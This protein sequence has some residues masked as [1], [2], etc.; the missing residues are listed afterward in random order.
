MNRKLHNHML[1]RLMAAFLAAA[2]L[3]LTVPGFGTRAEAAQKGIVD[4]QYRVATFFENGR[5]TDTDRR[6]AR[7][8]YIK[9]AMGGNPKAQLYLGE[10]YEDGFLEENIKPNIDAAFSWYIRAAIAGEQA[11]SEKA[12]YILS[13]GYNVH[14]DIGEA[15]D[16]LRRSAANGNQG[17]IEELERLKKVN[18]IDEKSDIQTTDGSHSAMADLDELIGMETIKKD[19]RELINLVKMQKLR[20][21]KGM[22]SL[23]VSLHMVFTGNPGTGKTTVARIMA[24]IYREIGVLSKGQLVEV[25]RAGLVAGYVG[26][27]AIKTQEKI[28]EANGGI[29][30]IDEAYTLAKKGNDY[31]QEAIDTLI[32]LMEKRRDNFIV[33][34]A[35]YPDLMK[36]FI[37]S[38]PG[39]KSRF[40]K[41]IHFPDYSSE[42][43]VQIFMSLCDKYEYRLTDEAAKVIREKIENHVK[44][45]NE[46]FSNGRDIRNM[47]ETIISNQASRVMTD[48]N[49][50]DEELM[51]INETDIG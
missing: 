24:D 3:L 50:S 1:K 13:H 30:F 5:G 45:K 19:V 25:D 8:W 49:I 2:L 12:E 4:A 23:P 9:A 36:E 40:N 42:E 6:K 34:V 39:L 38:N 27:T 31:G 26:Q 35:G 48:E 16:W 37:N 47:F 41:Y 22:K 29:L 15:L 10:M 18:A 51:T 46:Q 33:I 20:R 17:A 43:L 21:E 44:N 28:D 14:M 11:A 32:N 7:T